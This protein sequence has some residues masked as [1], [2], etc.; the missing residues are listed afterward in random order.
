MEKVCVNW[1][2]KAF[3]SGLVDAKYWTDFEANATAAAAQVYKVA[4]YAAGEAKLKEVLKEYAPKEII[5]VGGDENPA[6]KG[7]YSRL[8]EDGTKVYTEKFD[9][10]EHAASADVGISTAEFGVG[11]SGSLVVDNYSYEA[12]VT[13]MLPFVNVVFVNAN[14]MVE[15][16]TSACQIIGKVFQKGYCGFVTGPSRTAD[17]ERVLSLGVHGPNKLIIIAVENEGGAK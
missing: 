5:A 14:Y 7:I 13:S 6:L 10:A 4:D 8:S 12:R 1:P 9:I 3:I 16:I 11:E 2:E 17:I 15:N